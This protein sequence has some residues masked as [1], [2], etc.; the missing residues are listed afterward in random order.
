MIDW[1]LSLRRASVKHRLWALAVLVLCWLGTIQQWHNL[2]ADLAIARWLARADVVGAVF[3]TPMLLVILF[4]G[5][6]PRALIRDSSS[7]RKTIPQIHSEIRR[8]HQ[9]RENRSR[10]F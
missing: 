2:H 9:E 4:G 6:V 7:L 10:W 5:R 8:E 3:L 1:Y